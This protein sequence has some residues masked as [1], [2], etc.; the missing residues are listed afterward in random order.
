MA[1]AGGG[2]TLE[3]G[4]GTVESDTAAGP[5]AAAVTGAV[6]LAGGKGC[7]TAWATGAVESAGV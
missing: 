1:G 4:A 2:V 5:R 3:G 6:E 7:L